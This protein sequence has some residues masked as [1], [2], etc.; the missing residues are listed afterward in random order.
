MT[1]QEESYF[2]SN[3]FPY[4][5]II[6][7]AGEATLGEQQR[8]KMKDKTKK[9]KQREAI[10][11]AVCAL[12][13]SGGGI[14]VVRSDD[15]D[16]QY[17]KHG[18]GMDIE[19]ELKKL[20]SSSKCEYCDFQQHGS[21]LLMFIKTWIVRN[22]NPK[23]CTLE[24]GAFI[25]FLT[26]KK[27]LEPAEVCEH[28]EKKTRG[29]GK[30][31]RL[32][33]DTSPLPYIK[34]LLK[35]PFLLLDE[36][37]DVGES[38]VVEFKN[39]ASL[40]LIERMKEII[41]EYVSAFANNNGG[42]LIIGVDD[43]TH[44][45]KGCEAQFT[46]EKLQS[47]IEHSLSTLTHVHFDNCNPDRSNS[48]Q[49]FYNIT[50]KP[51]KDVND[52]DK[53]FV[54]FLKIKPFC[55]LIFETD[56]QSWI[57]DDNCNIKRL[58]ASEWTKMI[59][60]SS[61]LT[62][63]EQFERLTIGEEP[64]Q[65]KGVYRKKGLETFEQQQ[66]NLYGSLDGGVTVV[67]DGLYLDLKEEHPEL[68]G[69]LQP[70]ISDAEGIVI[71]SRSWA[72]DLELPSNPDVVCDALVLISGEHPKLYSVFKGD[73][74][75]KEF[76]YSQGTALALRQKL[77]KMGS[78]TGKLCVIPA[79][80]RLNSTNKSSQFSW[81]EII[82]PETYR[83]PDLDT[84]KKLLWSLAIV[85][86]HFRSFLSDKVG[87]DYFNLLTTEQY[88]ILSRKLFKGPYFVHGP[89]GT[90]KT[91]LAVMMIKKIKNTYNCSFEEILYICENAP[92]RDFVRRQDICEAVTRYWFLKDDYSNIK[93]IVADEAQNFQC[94]NGNWFSKAK[95]IVG[96]R[97][98]FYIFAD[99]FQSCHGRATGLP[100]VEEQNM[101]VLTKVIRSPVNIYRHIRYLMNRIASTS[102]L[103]FLKDIMKGSECSHEVAGS[104]ELRP[105]VAQEEI[106][107]YVA[108]TCDKYLSKG[109]SLKDIAIL[110]S[111]KEVVDGFRP[112]LT[113][114]MKK[115]SNKYKKKVSFVDAGNIFGDHIV[116][117]SVR[118]F[119][120]LERQ[121]V[122]AINPVCANPTV[123]DNVL[124]CA[125]SRATAK[126]H[127]L[128]EPH[129]RVPSY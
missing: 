113:Q 121:I 22:H 114:E 129:C 117:D 125:A 39:F 66:Y 23:L 44:R 25:R 5:D 55:C 127:V 43:K 19:N 12:L 85:L 80:L 94:G 24:S 98:S 72:V 34:K 104:W 8:N 28:M 13:N 123:D 9:E 89:P 73:I 62:L 78:Y 36:E 46:E 56:P 54:I 30:K 15:P 108:E 58:S 116:L 48:T 93:H 6:L 49:D 105:N 59:T 103:D 71:V 61:E 88:E 92:L 67:P 95:R 74:S 52:E 10:A 101:E 109:Y 11:R 20:I 119:S 82:Y 2:C 69:L 18:L 99:H 42:F 84:I 51:V 100:P 65:A 86:L 118:R 40:K 96:T 90:G 37:L 50:F 68:E 83:M 53:G 38:D 4:P 102:K 81:P 26:L 64:P 60:K 120:G 79:A 97:G 33:V 47:V 27:K 110:C 63:E 17:M 107:K 57:L 41:K 45:V 112:L 91:V 29:E 77:V 31:P 21:Y 14:V 3:L 122:F 75:E 35:E 32:S 128:Y 106:V 1:S 76:D 111:T 7:D 16:Y 115:L 70:L 87:T 126:I 124:L